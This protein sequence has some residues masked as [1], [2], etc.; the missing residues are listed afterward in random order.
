M[1]WNFKKIKLLSCNVKKYYSNKIEWNALKELKE[2]GFIYATTSNLNVI[3][4]KLSK[5]LTSF[6]IGFDPTSGNK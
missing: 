4:K 1:F 5:K 2:R 6:Y 3:E